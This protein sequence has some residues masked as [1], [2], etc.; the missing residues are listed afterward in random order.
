MN[1]LFI[2]YRIT[3]L[4]Y[5]LLTLLYFTLGVLST[6]TVFKKTIGRL[7]VNDYS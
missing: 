4:Y 3:I 1:N 5:N 2:P 7:V 6:A